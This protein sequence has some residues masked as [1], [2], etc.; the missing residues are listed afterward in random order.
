M[1]PPSPSPSQLCAGP[2]RAASLG[3]IFAFFKGRRP[4]GGLGGSPGL[5][6]LADDLEAEERGDYVPV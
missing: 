3:L 4:G 6:A 5:E 2:R 1:T